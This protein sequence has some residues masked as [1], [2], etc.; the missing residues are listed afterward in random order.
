MISAS[1]KSVFVT[2]ARLR[3][4]PP[5]VVIDRSAPGQISRLE[6]R[7]FEIGP[8]HTG[9]GQV[10]PIQYCLPQDATHQPHGL[11]AHI[12]R[13]IRVAEIGV[14]QVGPAEISGRA[15]VFKIC[16]LEVGAAKLGLEQRCVAK[17]CA[18]EIRFDRPGLIQSGTIQNGAGKISTVEC[19]SPQDRTREIQPREVE[20]IEAHA[21][22]IRRLCLGGIRQTLCHLFTAQ[23]GLGHPGQRHVDTLHRRLCKWR[24]D[25][26]VA[27]INTLTAKA[28]LNI[29]PPFPGSGALA[30]GW[31]I[32]A[33]IA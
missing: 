15:R 31:G 17:A 30:P 26:L 10:R 16:A 1:L 28:N 13:K 7:E 32:V 25:G 9:A 5:S 24:G 12:G 21:R 27:R 18:R 14:L 11:I 4:A 19:S 33:A 2:F 6:G 22:E 29:L 23:L 8:V 20:A 3:S